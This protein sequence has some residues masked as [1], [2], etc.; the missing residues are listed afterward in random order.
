MASSRSHP[1]LASFS[2][3]VGWAASFGM[4]CMVVPLKYPQY[5]AFMASRKHRGEGGPVMSIFFKIGDSVEEGESVVGH[6]DVLG[7]VAA[8]TVDLLG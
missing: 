7:H 2:V 1:L 4:G 8:M 5:V 6:G 3:F